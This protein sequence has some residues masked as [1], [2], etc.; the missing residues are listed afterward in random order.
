LALDGVI[1]YVEMHNVKYLYCNGDVFHTP[2]NIP[3]QALQVASDF[4]RELRNLGC[5]YRLLVGNHDM[6]NKSGGINALK[7]LDDGTNIAY[8]GVPA[9]WFDGGLPIHGLG[10]CE[11]E[12]TII[13]FL[14]DAGRGGERTVLLL[15]QGV[16]GVPLSSGYIID[17]RLT[18]DMIPDNCFAFTGHYHFHRVVTPN[19]I[20]VGNL[21][22]LSWS[23][24]D[25]EKGFVSWDDETGAIDFIPQVGAPKFLS[26]EP[27]QLLDMDG[28]FIRYSAEVEAGEI[29]KLRADLKEDG[30]RMV[31]FPYVKSADNKVFQTGVAFDHNA[32]INAV[33]EDDMEPRRSEVGIEIREEKYNVPG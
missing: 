25:Q 5:E 14:E 21:T 22:A 10:Y 32:L 6:A 12:D 2:G 23:D 19:L 7:F 3:T 16:A 29:P 31:E 24:I 15:H 30:A 1:D 20:V 26:Y 13:K 17:E 8:P 11:D 9:R 27:G 33:A 28:H 18:P 4:F